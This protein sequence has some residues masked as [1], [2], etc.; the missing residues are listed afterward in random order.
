[1]V[2]CLPSKTE[3]PEFK[4][5]YYQRKKK[6]KK[7]ERLDIVGEVKLYLFHF[8]FFPLPFCFLG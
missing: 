4:L 8:V 1:M 7:K 6:K 3:G 2:E 5:Q